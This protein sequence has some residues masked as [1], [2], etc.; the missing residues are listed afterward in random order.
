MNSCKT[1]LN[2]TAES[3]IWTMIIF[4]HLKSMLEMLQERYSCSW[5]SVKTALKL[6]KDQII[7]PTTHKNRNNNTISLFDCNDVWYLPV[8][9]SMLKNFTDIAITY[10]Q[11]SN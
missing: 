7:E 2:T 3:E 6:M 11:F 8:I 10:Y 1:T 5:K 9:N 4:Y